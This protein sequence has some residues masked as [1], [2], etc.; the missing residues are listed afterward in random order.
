[1][2]HR[3]IVGT[4]ISMNTVAASGVTTSFHIQTPSL[5][6]TTRDHDAHVVI[7]QASG[8]STT[9]T[10]ADY[11][12]LADTSQT[13]AM[14]RYSCKIVAITQEDGCTL[15]CPEGQQVPFNI[16]NYVTL[17]GAT[18]SNYNDKIVHSR[19]TAVDAAAGTYDG[20]FQTK[21]TLDADTSGITTAFSYNSVNSDVTLYSSARI[22]ARSSGGAGSVFA[23]Q[24]QTTGDA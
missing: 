2:A 24:V 1:M 10:T 21:V 11:L 6:I 13:L 19:V 3:P 23:Q 17:K 8:I 12:I 20:V 15:T 14:S 5:R 16:G 22:G 7:S 9:A 18:E 4:G